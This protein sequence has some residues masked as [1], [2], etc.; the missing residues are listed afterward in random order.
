MNVSASQKRALEITELVEHEER[1]APPPLSCSSAF[2]AAKAPGSLMLFQVV[3]IQ[4]SERWMCA[5]RN[6]SIWPL[7]GSAMPLTC[8]PMEV[9]ALAV[10]W[11]RAGLAAR[12]TGSPAVS[13]A[14]ACRKTRA[15]VL[16]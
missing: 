2:A 7:K 12:R 6:S 13:R 4:P 10:A 15:K 9:V 16:S 5:M 1:M 11:V 3:A 8:R 14:A